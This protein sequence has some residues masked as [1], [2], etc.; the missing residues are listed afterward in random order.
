MQRCSLQTFIRAKKAKQPNFPSTGELVNK[1]R[2]IHVVDSA[3]A[4]L[5]QFYIYNEDKCQKR[6]IEQK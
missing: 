5:H 4:D 6:N 1:P 2:F 3:S